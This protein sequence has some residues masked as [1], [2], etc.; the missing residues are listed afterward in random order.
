MADSTL[1]FRPFLSYRSPTTR[2]ASFSS[3]RWQTDLLQSLP[4]LS[5]G[6]LFTKADRKQTQPSLVQPIAPHRHSQSHLLFPAPLASKPTA[7]PSQSAGRGLL[8]REGKEEE[9]PLG[10]PPLHKQ[11]TACDTS[12]H[13]CNVQLP[14]NLAKHAFNGGPGLILYLITH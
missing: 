14:N 9:E 11:I 12:Q 2:T 6:S 5:F 13:T 8:S 7:P 10:T 4:C 3:S 1:R